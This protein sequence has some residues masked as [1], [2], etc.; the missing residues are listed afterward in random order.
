MKRKLT[1]N[2]LAFGNLRARKKQ[3]TLMIIGISLAMVFSS[4]VLFFLFC[5]SESLTELSRKTYGCQ[6]GIILSAEQS[7]LDEAINDNI[8]D[9][10]ALVQ[11][12]GYI[13]TN[14]GTEEKGALVAKYDEKA[15]KLAYCIADVGRL[16]ESAGE[17]AVENDALT[18]M[19]ISAEVGDKITLNYKIQN[20]DGFLPREIKKTYTLVGILRDKRSNLCRDNKEYTDSIPAAMVSYEEQ[21]EPGGK[22]KAIY[23]YTYPKAAYSGKDT[24]GDDT[25]EGWSRAFNFLSKNNV[26]FLITYRNNWY[27]ST[28]SSIKMKTALASVLAGT[29]LL[30]SCV[31]IVNAFNSN[32]LER[33]K[34]IGM[35]R[36]IGTTKRQIVGIFGREA[37]IIAM[38]S[39]T[40]S[41]LL[42]YFGTKGVITLLG[43]SFVFL[44]KIQILVLCGVFGIICVMAAALIPLIHASKI[45]PIQ[46]IRNI[47]MTRKLGR[48]KI[49]PKR[50]FSVPGLLAK[51]GMTFGRA[52]IISVSFILAVAIVAT[53]V[54]FTVLDYAFEY[55][56]YLDCDYRLY[57]QGVSGYTWFDNC[58]Q[59]GTYGINPNGISEIL[60]SRHVKNVLCE[61]K[62]H[63]N[64]ITDELTPYM[65][66]LS[67]SQKDTYIHSDSQSYSPDITA[68]NFLEKIGSAVDEHEEMFKEEFGCM[69]SVYYTDITAFD[70]SRIYALKDKVGEGEIDIDKLN[71]GEEII[72]VAPRKI[73]FGMYVM[74]YFGGTDVTF[75]TVRVD[76]NGRLMGE[77]P[78]ME[79]TF[80]LL[81]C[82]DL[83]Y[84]AGNEVKLSL[85]FN[86]S[87]IDEPGLASGSGINPFKGQDI[88]KYDKTVKIGAIIY[89]ENYEY[90]PLNCVF[91][92]TNAGLAC[93]GCEPNYTAVDITLKEKCTPEI[94]EDMKRLL[95]P[96]ISGLYFD[97]F[98]EYEMQQSRDTTYRVTL[99]V[100]ISLI[101]LMFCISASLIN[102]AL[103]ARIRE[104][105][106]E[107]G[108]LRAVGASARELMRSYV[109][110]LL[111]MF[112]IGTALGFGIYFLAF[113]AA[114]TVCKYKGIVMPFE[115][116]IF[117]ALAVCTLMFALCG[118][119]LWVQIRKQ[120]KYS[121]I[122]NI[123]EL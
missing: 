79:E 62:R 26:R 98:S 118:A 21:L 38:I 41:L 37:F 91:L 121:I 54:G 7:L 70:E 24:L 34:Q 20:G 117:K 16:P 95:A 68:D 63:I 122:E 78:G 100:L 88:R 90:H 50:E 10:Y 2:S 116:D 56:P 6:N 94:N 119:N 112:G 96:I 80:R 104:S 76:G 55:S 89:S 42:S 106:R 87:N 64:L 31:G 102:N 110:Q 27:N 57:E 67:L 84:H 40:P 17:I 25:S 60:S 73:G 58:S 28:T 105:K 8:F 109:L 19:R 108:T 120:M 44:P 51:R 22:G 53:C 113:A 65:R 11:V 77:Y 61:E 115:F 86:D 81:T 66:L 74:P 3:Y 5:M 12:I 15:Q 45:S 107:I 1:V 72:L 82:E 123:R 33:K 46:A 13:Y 47:D 101:V 114:E 48:K 69:G 71:S 30:A 23:Y 4:G 32:L 9:D 97:C 99:T 35:L 83:T 29:L 103:T 111:S 43:D 85:L 14:S 49:S 52:K 75:D 36:A 39:V 59:N 93:F 92:T 18:R